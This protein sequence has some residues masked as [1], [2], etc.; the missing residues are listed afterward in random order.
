MRVVTYLDVTFGTNVFATGAGGTILH[1]HG[2]TRTAQTSGTTDDLTGVT[3]TGVAGDVYAV[4]DHGTIL[5]FN[6]TTWTKQR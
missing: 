5:H 6:G 1:S 4:G 3:S 2:V